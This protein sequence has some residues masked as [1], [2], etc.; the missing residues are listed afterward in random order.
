MPVGVGRVE[1]RCTCIVRSCQGR[2][3]IGRYVAECPRKCILYVLLF[4]FFGILYFIFIVIFIPIII[5][6]IFLLYMAG[7]V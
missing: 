5:I 7:A 4:N 3:S 2:G 6:I 1:L